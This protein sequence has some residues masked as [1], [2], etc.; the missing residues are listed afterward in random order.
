MEIKHSYLFGEN[1]NQ[2]DTRRYGEYTITDHFLKIQS[3]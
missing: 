3:N 1:M 2:I